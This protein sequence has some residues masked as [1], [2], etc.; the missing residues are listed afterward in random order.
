[1]E[2]KMSK[3][4]K[5]K[6][7]KQIKAQLLQEMTQV[8]AISSVNIKSQPSAEEKVITQ[9]TTTS[10]FDLPQ[11]KYDLKKTLIVILILAA[12]IMGL[13]FADL[14]YGLLAHFGTWLFKVLNIK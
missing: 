6:F 4:N 8:S 7:K 13:Y 11:V 9:P 5:N 12:L 3:K 14:K 1:M 2:R 10:A